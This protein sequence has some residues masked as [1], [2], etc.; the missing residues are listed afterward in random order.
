MGGQVWRL[1]VLAE[2]ARADSEEPSSDPEA[3]VGAWEGQ[4]EDPEA[5]VGQVLV[6]SDSVLA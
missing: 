5:E 4:E 3:L 6:A 2:V 1:S